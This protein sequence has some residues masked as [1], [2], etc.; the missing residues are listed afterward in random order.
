MS[1]SMPGQKN[2]DFVSDIEG[3]FPDGQRHHGD[4]QMQCPYKSLAILAE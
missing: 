3:F 4:L 1:S 2:K